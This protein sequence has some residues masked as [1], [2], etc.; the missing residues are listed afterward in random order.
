[1]EYTHKVRP[2]TIMVRVWEITRLSGAVIAAMVDISKQLWRLAIWRLRETM[3]T[4][5]KPKERNDTAEFIDIVKQLSKP[6]TWPVID[7]LVE[8]AHKLV[9]LSMC[10]YNN[11]NGSYL[12]YTY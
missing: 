4:Y 8:K 5:A 6:H 12:E 11:D 1:M 9:Y 2:L 7:R 3:G 10:D